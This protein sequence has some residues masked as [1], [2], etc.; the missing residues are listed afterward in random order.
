[1]PSPY[2]AVGRSD[3]GRK[4]KGQMSWQLRIFWAVSQ[5]GL[6]GPEIHVRSESH[7]FSSKG[8]D[9]NHRSHVLG[10]HFIFPSPNKLRLSLSH[11]SSPTSLYLTQHLLNLC[12]DSPRMLWE[13]KPSLFLRFSQ[14][15]LPGK[16]PLP[17][18]LGSILFPWGWVPLC[19]C[20]ECIYEVWGSLGSA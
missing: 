13:I 8:M 2:C 10:A 12:L 15:C 19:V 11:D 4:G 6:H 5:M 9:K 18:E 20:S 17:S 1:M 14:F 7:G 16:H 3:S